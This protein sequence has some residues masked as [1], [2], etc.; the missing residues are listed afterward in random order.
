M[1]WSRVSTYLLPRRRMAGDPASCQRQRQ[2]FLENLSA[3]A[4]VAVLVASAA[5]SYY[6]MLE[7]VA[8]TEAA[9][10]VQGYRVNVA[11][12]YAVTGELPDKIATDDSSRRPVGRYFDRVE[13]RDHEVV[14]DLSEALVTR[15]GVAS[16]PPPRS[17]A[18]TLSFPVALT[19]DGRRLIFAC[20][21]GSVP[22]GFGLPPVR[23]TTLPARRLPGFC[24]N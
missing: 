17:P 14:L 23:H 24:R 9:S 12:H 21:F 18:D 3:L 4:I 22:A 13:W 6:P 19:A 20:G 2:I 10:L 11:E 5:R 8:V 16:A 1:R 15:F 7:K